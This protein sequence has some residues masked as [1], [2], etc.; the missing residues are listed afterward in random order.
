MTLQLFNADC[1]E[2]MKLLPD[3]SIYLIICD[4]PYGCLTGGKGQE[5]KRKNRAMIVR[6]CMMNMSK[7]SMMVHCLND[8]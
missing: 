6:K 1:L 2:Q 7:S 5:K 8:V 3:K 4:L